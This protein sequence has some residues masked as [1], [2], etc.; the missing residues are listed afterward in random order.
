MA[1]NSLVPF[2]KY[3]GQPVEVLAQDRDYADW[4]L[5]QAWFVQRYPQVHT[6]VVNNF[7]EPTETPEHNALQIRCL[8]ERFRL[9]VTAAAL[10]FFHPPHTEIDCGQLNSIVGTVVP[11][12]ATMSPPTFEHVGVDVTWTVCPWG[13]CHETKMTKQPT[14]LQQRYAEACQQA[15]TQIN[16]FVSSARLRQRLHARREELTLQLRT[17]IAQQRQSGHR[18]SFGSP[19]IAFEKSLADLQHEHCLDRVVGWLQCRD[20]STTGGSLVVSH[21]TY[22]PHGE[23]GESAL[24]M[25]GR[26][27]CQ[28][29]G[30]TIADDLLHLGAHK[31]Y[32]EMAVTVHHHTWKQQLQSERLSIECKSWLGDDYPAVLRQMKHVPG[33]P[34]HLVLLAGAVQSQ[35]VPLEA[36]RKFFALSNICLLLVDEVEQTA[37][38]RLWAKDDLPLAHEAYT[39]FNSTPCEECDTMARVEIVPF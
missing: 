4:L 19:P 10:A 14:W 12:L 27:E 16:T 2:G 38:A 25:Y 32:F 24:W 9:Q 6:L 36:I 5:A 18:S 17:E 28:A 1:E 8:D 31:D 33:N 34:G 35:T 11:Y 15:R 29:Y 26:R 23:R 22:P 21:T 3:K 39:E 30:Q 13:V 7:G 20:I 37:P